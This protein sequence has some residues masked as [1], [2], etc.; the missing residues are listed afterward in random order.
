MTG[1]EWRCYTELAK[2]P[3]TAGEL[4]LHTGIAE[5]TLWGILRSFQQR[6]LVKIAY[7]KLRGKGSGS[8]RGKA[9]YQLVSEAEVLGRRPMPPLPAHE[10]AS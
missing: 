3:L 6:G 4:Q 1:L 8:G 5:G 10:D 9:I 2:G 7:V